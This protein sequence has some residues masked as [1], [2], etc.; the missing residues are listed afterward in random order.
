M[1]EDSVVADLE[2]LPVEERPQR[3][4][5]YTA[6]MA[7]HMEEEAQRRMSHLFNLLMGM[8]VACEPGIPYAPLFY[9]PLEHIMETNPC[10]KRGNYNAF[11]KIMH[12][13]H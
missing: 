6:K 12:N 11:M 7:T 9:R 2:N 4:T 10:W 8:L 1:E 13:I 5:T 3:R